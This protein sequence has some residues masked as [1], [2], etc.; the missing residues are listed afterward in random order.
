[1]VIDIRRELAQ[2]R[3]INNRS[4]VFSSRVGF[5]EQEWRTIV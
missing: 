1:V 5:A 4:V 3:I 2:T